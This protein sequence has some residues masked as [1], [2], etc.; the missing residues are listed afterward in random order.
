MIG[1]DLKPAVGIKQADYYLG[2][3]SIL[4]E[5][6]N[7]FEEVEVYHKDILDKYEEKNKKEARELLINTLKQKAKISGLTYEEVLASLSKEQL[8]KII[9]K[10]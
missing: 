5:E 3:I 1:I 2:I 4:I 7:K 6:L 8:I 9:A 10:D